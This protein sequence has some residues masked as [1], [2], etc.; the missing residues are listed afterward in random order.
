MNEISREHPASIYAFLRITSLDPVQQSMSGIE[1]FSKCFFGMVYLGT[2]L[3]P[4]FL[5]WLQNP[6]DAA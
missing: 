3:L 6:T 4:A 5:S 1:N 2:G